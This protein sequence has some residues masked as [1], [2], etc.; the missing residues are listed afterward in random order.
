MLTGRVTK[1]RNAA[2]KNAKGIVEIAN[3]VETELGD[4]ELDGAGAFEGKNESDDWEEDV[5]ARIKKEKDEED[6]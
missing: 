4:V 1:A 5:A 3:G 2:K 6:D